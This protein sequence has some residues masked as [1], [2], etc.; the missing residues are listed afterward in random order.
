MPPWESGSG[1]TYE[2]GSASRAGKPVPRASALGALLQFKQM[3]ADAKLGKHGWTRGD[4]N[5]LG[6]IIN[7]IQKGID[8]ADARRNPRRNG[9]RVWHVEFHPA[10]GQTARLKQ[11]VERWS[12]KLNTRTFVATFAAADDAQHATEQ[13]SDWGIAGRDTRVAKVREG[14]ARKNA[15]RNTGKLRWAKRHPFLGE[16]RP[17]Y[18]AHGQ[19]GT[20]RISPFPGMGWT[21]KWSDATHEAFIGNYGTLPRAKAAAEQAS[22]G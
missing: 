1:P 4:V 13:A 14:A 6:R 8:E 10:V 15:R 20:F 2:L 17:Y 9:R 16:K 21:V 3:Q 7:A 22:I 11:I 19:G 18:E 12:G 5:Q